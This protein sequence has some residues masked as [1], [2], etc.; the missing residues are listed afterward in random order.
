MQPALQ[1]KLLRILEERQVRHVGGSENIPV[2]VTVIATTNINLADAV[3]KGTFRS[4]L[5]YRLNSFHI[6]MPSLHERKEDI[7]LLARHFISLF[8]GKYNKKGITSLSGEAEK[9][10][11][12]HPW[13][14]NIRELKNCI[15][16]L[17]VLGNEGEILAEHLPAEMTSTLL[18]TDR[19]AEGRFLLP[20]AGISL[21]DFERD[22][23][24]QALERTKHNKAQAA[25]LLNLTYDT[26]RYQ[27]KKYG[28]E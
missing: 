21:E 2:N 11:V 15:E 19:A 18:A 3:K 4:D 28:L 27:V 10:I 8:S 25:K 17:V 9:I 1:S 5:F 20:D 7:L 24:I 23:I 12:S 26:L 22:I 13:P 16:R 6:T 14:G